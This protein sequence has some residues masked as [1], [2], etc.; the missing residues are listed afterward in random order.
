MPARAITLKQLIFPVVLGVCLTVVLVRAARDGGF[1]K[2]ATLVS[3]F[4]AVTLTG[5]AVFLAS[6]AFARPDAGVLLLVAMLVAP[7]A[8]L[9]WAI[10]RSL[11]AI[12]QS[13][14]ETG[15]A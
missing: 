6:W 9:A 8:L 13:Q 7:F 5:G 14:S 11:R 2:V 10:Y 4:L 3:G 12:S 15:A 1:R